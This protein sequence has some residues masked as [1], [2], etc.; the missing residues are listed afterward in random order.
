MED[1]EEN[2]IEYGLPESG[3]GSVIGSGEG[4]EVEKE[5]ARERD[6]EME[7]ERK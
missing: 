1:K 6:G 5:R 3:E 4:R 2:Y 7:K